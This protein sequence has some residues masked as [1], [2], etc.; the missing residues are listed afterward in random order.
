M[1][2][3]SPI[4]CPCKE[5]WVANGQ[6]MWVAGTAYP[7]GYVVEHPATSGNLY[8]PL[9]S[10]GVSSGAGEPG[11]DIHWVLCNGNGPSPGPCDG[12]SVAVWDN[13]TA[14]AIG[15][16][17]QFPANSGTYF[18]IVF[19]HDDAS[20][21]PDWVADPVMD[22]GL[23]EFWTPY[24]CPCEETWTANGEPVWDNTVG[25]YSGNYVVEW[26][27]GSDE[28]YLAEGGG[29]T[30]AGEPGVDGH[31]IKCVADEPETDGSEPEATPAKDSESSGLPSIGAFA[32]VVGILAASAFVRREDDR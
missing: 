19:T 21:G 31:W 16:V 23:D 28:L 24:T 4:D 9:E 6:P 10:G 2:V 30:G 15:D 29:I 1:D 8:T 11:V 18:Q 32:T 5:T 14:P 3:W 25:F 17:Y 26:P 20:G 27:A 13:T 22:G 7:G 12:L